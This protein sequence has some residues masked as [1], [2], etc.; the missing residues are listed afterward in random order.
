MELV[1]SLHPAGI[2]PKCEQLFDQHGY[3][4]L[5]K[6]YAMEGAFSNHGAFYSCA[7]YSIQFRFWMTALGH[8]MDRSLPI[9]P[10]S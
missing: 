10:T 5:S 6:F 7:L 3:A 1:G 4:P 2:A 9:H 8:L